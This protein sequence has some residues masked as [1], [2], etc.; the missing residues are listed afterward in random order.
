MQ[1][2]H[3]LAGSA[4]AFL[5]I[6]A[7]KRVHSTTSSAQL[8][9][10]PVLTRSGKVDLA[11]SCVSLHA[12]FQDLEELVLGK[13]ERKEPGKIISFIILHHLPIN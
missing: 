13:K 3:L 10:P 4:A 12:Y 2:V 5:F 11:I 9:T 7:S 6:P 1:P 8:F